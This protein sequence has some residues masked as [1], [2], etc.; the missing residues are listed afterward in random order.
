MRDQIHP[1]LGTGIPSPMV[2][3][4]RSLDT[5]DPPD[6]ARQAGDFGAGC[7]G[8]RCG[9]SAAGEPAG[10]GVLTSRIVPLRGRGEPGRAGVADGQ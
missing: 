3:A 7:D 5:R 9:D 6:L 2:T 4:P 8:C 1:R 10:R